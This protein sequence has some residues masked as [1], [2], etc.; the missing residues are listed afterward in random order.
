[1]AAV[2]LA[3]KQGFLADGRERAWSIR[4][5][6]K[7]GPSGPRPV[8]VTDSAETLKSVISRA[9]GPLEISKVQ[10]V[11]ASFGSGK[12][13]QKVTLSLEQAGSQEVGGYIGE[14]DFASNV[15]ELVLADGGAGGE[16][17]P[18]GVAIGLDHS[19]DGPSTPGHVAQGE[20]PVVKA[21]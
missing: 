12:E 8:R 16:T 21:E 14:G 1:M 20:G 11:K 4:L 17:N 9:I 5:I 19:I 3:D 7:G 6:V 18:G 15:L 13:E 2:R 10:S